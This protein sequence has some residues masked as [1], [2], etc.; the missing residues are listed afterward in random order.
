[1]FALA[2]Q[3][4]SPEMLCMHGFVYTV[5]DSQVYFSFPAHL[6]LIHGREVNMDPLTYF[7]FSLHLDRFSKEMKGEDM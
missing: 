6:V 1:M 7:S 3:A 4:N 5:T 2:K